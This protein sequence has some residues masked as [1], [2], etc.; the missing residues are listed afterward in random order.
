MLRWKKTV[1]LVYF[2]NSVGAKR[3]Y[4]ADGIMPAYFGVAS[5]QARAPAF[6]DSGADVF[7][8]LVAEAYL[9]EARSVLAK[10][11]IRL[12]PLENLERYIDAI[13]FAPQKVASSS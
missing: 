13:E 8:A 11:M 6:G 1:P 12:G 9:N 3:G 7:G 5:G 4:G 10:L 2:Y